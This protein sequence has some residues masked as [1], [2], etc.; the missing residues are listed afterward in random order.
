M[1]RNKGSARKEKEK[2]LKLINTWKRYKKDKKKGEFWNQQ[3]KGE[4]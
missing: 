4:S 2:N 1:R 3:S